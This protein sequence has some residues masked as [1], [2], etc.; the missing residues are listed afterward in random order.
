LALAALAGLG[1]WP[2]VRAAADPRQ[3]IGGAGSTNWNTPADWQLSLIPGAGDDA[4]VTFNDALVRTILY[5]YP[6]PAVT[7]N[8]VTISNSGTGSAT[9]LVSANALTTAN[10]TVGAN[11]IV[12]VSG[13]TISVT[14]NLILDGTAATLNL[15]GGALYAFEAESVGYNGKGTLNQTGGSNV[16]YELVA[17]YNPGA[18]GTVNLSDGQMTANTL[19]VGGF[20]SAG[21]NGVF[22]LSG[23]AQL[24]VVN[25]E[26]AGVGGTGTFNQSGGVH[27]VG[28]TLYVGYLAGSTG[29]YNLSGGS[30]TTPNF[31]V[32]YGQANVTGSGIL[33]ATNVAVLKASSKLT[34]NGSGTVNASSVSVPNWSN[35]NFIKGTLNLAGG[36]S[37]NTGILWLGSGAVTGAVLNLNSGALYADTESV[38]AG[39]GSGGTF[40]QTGGFSLTKY[41]TVGQDPGS[42]GT[43]ILS[44]GNFAVTFDEVIGEG[45][46][47]VFN[48]SGG[49]HSVGHNLTVGDAELTI[50][51]ALLRGNGT[52]NLSPGATLS[53]TNNETVGGF[54]NGILNQT[55]GAHAIGGTLNIAL[56]PG[57][58]GTVNLSGGSLMAAATA[59]N[60]TINH[61]GGSASLGVVTGTGS[62]LIG[63]TSGAAVNMNVRQFTQAAVTIRNAGMLTVAT[64]AA[65]FTNTAT[66][67]SIAIDPS[68]LHTTFNYSNNGNLDLANHTL[69]TNTD[70]TTIKTYL[71]NGYDAFNNA[72]WGGRGITSS[73]VH[74]NPI[75][76]SLAYASGSDQSAQDAGIA[77]APGQVFVR[78][79][80]T[81]DANIDGTVDFFDIS[82]ILGYKYNT[83]Q[84]ASYTDGDL[85]Y[86]GVVDF[87]DISLLLSA[88]YNTGI[89]FALSTA[90]A[91]AAPAIGRQATASIPEPICMATVFAALGGAAWLRPRRRRRS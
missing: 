21:A 57:S 78:P 68:A 73:F 91:A 12:H 38:G 54:G 32:V 1:A 45:G 23:A 84:P 19:I 83:G 55:G 86:D 77:V 49:T 40:N 43:V 48:Q 18:S 28:N 29:T 85:N 37:S 76:Y 35:L 24:T 30:L 60:G 14:Q 69:F 79:V 11:G 31:D 7:L 15:N 82:Q 61:T 58:T 44:A 6:G 70:P 90:A 25:Y 72:D 71:Q 46:F 16:S 33:N 80:L 22:N 36:V 74:A 39:D 20:A 42:A 81:G 59:N 87:F 53:V 13:G 9:L 51:W 67:L 4:N 2:N 88:N 63:N 47:G 41:I 8:S 56:Q 26:G 64:N 66:A 17:G 75:K 50:D 10:A 62:L 89:V 52:F 5:D 27:T 65:R 34:L 3:Y